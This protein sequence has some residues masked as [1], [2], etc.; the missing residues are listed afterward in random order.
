MVN[1]ADKQKAL[2][3]DKLINQLTSN[4]CMDTLLYGA[5]SIMI[6][7]MTFDRKRWS[8]EIN[9]HGLNY[10]ILLSMF[11]SSFYV[12]VPPCHVKIITAICPQYDKFSFIFK[13]HVI[14][15]WFE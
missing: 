12:I 3:T 1:V 13:F 5:A 14:W 2:W 6:Q 10:N 7:I 8:E 4:Q 15:V 9:L 11:S